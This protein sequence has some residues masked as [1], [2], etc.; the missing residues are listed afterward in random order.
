MSPRV[1]DVDAVPI[2]PTSWAGFTRDMNE[3]AE[4]FKGEKVL[5]GLSL[6]SSIALRA[7]QLAPDLYDKVYLMAPKLRNE[8][9]F[10]NKILTDNID[11]FGVE[12][13]I[14]NMRTGWSICEKEEAL[15]PHNRPGFCY[16]NI[17]HAVAMI[18]FG[19][20]VMDAAAAGSK[21]GWKTRTQ[22]QFALSHGDDGVSN[23]AVKDVLADLH[24]TNN[25]AKV[26]MMPKVIPHSMFSLR[27]QPYDKPWLPALFQTIEDFF[28][29][30]KNVT[31]SSD[32]VTDCSINW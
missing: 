3:I 1:D 23:N 11:T 20:Q 21:K 10:L 6:G 30:G 27:D 26:C 28:V 4:K 8:T 2:S 5:V 24:K 13:Y 16:M 18:D 25:N 32:A 22:I 15:P 12:D 29:S 9:A 19:T 31:G 7:V 17:R 14:L